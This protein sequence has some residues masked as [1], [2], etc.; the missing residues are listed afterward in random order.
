[1]PRGVPLEL[2]QL[3]NTVSKSRVRLMP[4]VK[5]GSRKCA[6]GRSSAYQGHLGRIAG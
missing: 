3:R 4:R 6:R 5:T 2:A 1:M